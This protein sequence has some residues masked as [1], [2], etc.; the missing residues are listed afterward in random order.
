MLKPYSFVCGYYYLYSNRKLQLK[1]IQDS[2]TIL[3]AAYSF[4]LL[5]KKTL[6]RLIN[7]M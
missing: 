1:Y 3:Y 5:L 4:F 7:I 6:S 2:Q